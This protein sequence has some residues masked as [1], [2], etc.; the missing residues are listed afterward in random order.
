MAQAGSGMTDADW[1]AFEHLKPEKPAVRQMFNGLA[2]KIAT[3]LPRNLE[4]AVPLRK[5]LESKDAAVRASLK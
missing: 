5:L 1:F 3:G 2:H 4:R